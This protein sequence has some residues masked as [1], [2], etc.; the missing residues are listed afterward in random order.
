MGGLASCVS[1]SKF[2]ECS[3][4]SSALAQNS[5]YLI[6]TS[7][8]APRPSRS[9]CGTMPSNLTPAVSKAFSMKSL[10]SSVK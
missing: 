4:V 10:I 8:I 1:A 7:G 2:I 6:S 9:T 5:S 3:A